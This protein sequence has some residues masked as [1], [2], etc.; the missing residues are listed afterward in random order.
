MRWERG[1]FQEHLGNYVGCKVFM[2]EL[3]GIGIE[4]FHYVFNRAKKRFIFSYVR[5]IRFLFNFQL[6]GHFPSEL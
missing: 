5:D 4:I 3:L 6:I 2:S 1:N